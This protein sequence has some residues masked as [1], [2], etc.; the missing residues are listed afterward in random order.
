LTVLS[1]NSISERNNTRILEPRY[2]ALGL[3]PRFRLVEDFDEWKL[4][5]LQEQERAE[6]LYL[7]TNG[8][9]R[10]WH[11]AAA[12]DW[13]NRHA[14]VPAFTCDDFMVPYVAFGLTK[15]AREQGEW[16]AAAALAILQGRSPA[17]IPLAANRRTEC[18]INETQ[19]RRS[20]LHLPASLG[21]KPR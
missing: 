3:E 8:A 10:G 9:I 18:W 15:V 13:A 21:C 14:R 11:A 2:R 4:A 5:Y 1:E 19:Y 20:G 7:P 17:Q 6:V 16:A 12:R